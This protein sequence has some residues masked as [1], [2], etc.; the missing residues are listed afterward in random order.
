MSNQ[1]NNRKSRL[2]GSRLT[3]VKGGSRSKFGN[4]EGF[5]SKKIDRIEITKCIVALSMVLVL[6]FLITPYI[7]IPGQFL[8]KGRIATKNIKSPA[9]FLIEDRLSTEKNRIKA[10]EGQL[11]IYDF[12]TKIAGQVIERIS[13]AFNLINSAYLSGIPDFTY[14]EDKEEIDQEYQTESLLKQ[15]EEMRQKILLFESSELFKQKEK[16][17][18]EILG[19][20]LNEKAYKTLRWHHYKPEI[21]NVLINFVNRVMADGVVSDRKLLN[22]EK[23]RAILVR[24][25]GSGKETIIEA[26]NVHDMEELMFLLKKT[27]N[28]NVDKRHPSLRKVIA[29]MARVLIRLN[30][31]FNKKETE[32]AKSASVGAVKPVFFQIKKGEMI[33]R[34]GERIT[35]EHI[36]KLKGMNPEGDGKNVFLIPF[37]IAVF[38]LLVFYLGWF[39]LRKFK[40]HIIKDNSSLLLLSTILVVNFA[41]VRL[42]IVT[43]QAYAEYMNININSFYYAIPYAAGTMLVSILF[44]IDM[45]IVFSLL[46]FFLVG[47]LMEGGYSYSLVALTGG[48]VATF[49]VN[50]YKHRSDILKTGLII[51]IVNMVT[52]LPL[53]IIN[54]SIFSLQGLYDILMG[55]LGGL[56]IA[57]VVS[58]VLPILESIFKVTSDIRLLELADPNHPILTRMV[59]HA[60]GTYQHSHLVANL[61]EEAAEAVGANPLL[62]RV[63]SYFHDIGKMRKA[64]YFMENQQIAGGGGSKH[65]KLTPSMSSLVLTSH[66][67]D[68]I[69]IAKEFKLIPKIIDFIREHHGNGLIT[70]FYNKAKEQYNPDTESIKEQDFRYSGPRPRTKETAIV[71]L[72]DSVEAASRSLEEPTPSRLKGLVHK[73]IN[74]KFIDGQLDDCDISLKDLNKIAESFIRILIGIFHYRVDYHENSEEKGK[75]DAAA[76]N[77]EKQSIKGENRSSG[78]KRGGLK[79]TKKIEM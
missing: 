1:E 13:S 12:D 54:Y 17:F 5:A 58:I 60:P 40:S 25:L 70:Y 8:E 73:V 30:L 24:K 14:D 63:G 28:N 71:M 43:S 74:N 33:V 64:E 37:G 76:N 19:I 29:D 31:T 50:Q 52:I 9:D 20:E 34:E 36:M 77:G 32:E 59:V 3:L 48:L 6:T 38:I 4:L 57:M 53:G 15:K 56:I 2:T 16:K 7:R 51:G 65:D 67:K 21:K 46:T 10:A 68:G 78:N 49:R 41:L 44:D 47:L 42:F 45:G 22:L 39:Y 26:D 55:F 69:E 61:S 72:A 11:D 23:K 27:I 18:T 62:V 35:Q 66:V 79:D 75:N